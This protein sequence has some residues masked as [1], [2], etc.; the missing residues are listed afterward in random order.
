LALH[1]D[2]SPLKARSDGRLCCVTGKRS[3]DPR[4]AQQGDSLLLILY[5][6]VIGKIVLQFLAWLIA[7][8]IIGMPMSPHLLLEALRQ[9]LF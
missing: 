1:W 6:G 9:N 4:Q 3:Y 5:V 2:A 8:S 7:P